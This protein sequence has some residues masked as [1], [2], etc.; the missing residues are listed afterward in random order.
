MQMW[1]NHSEWLNNILL[2]QVVFKCIEA[3]WINMAKRKEKNKFNQN[4]YEQKKN[5]NSTR[6]CNYLIGSTQIDVK[7]FFL[8]L[9]IF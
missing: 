2:S 6:F 8:L 9:I 5:I 3:S 1:F 4:N 7:I